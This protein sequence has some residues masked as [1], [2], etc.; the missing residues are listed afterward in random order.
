LG[1]QK[2]IGVDQVRATRIVKDA[3]Q[4]NQLP[5]DPFPTA[6]L[7]GRAR[8][9]SLDELKTVYDLQHLVKCIEHIYRENEYESWFAS[10]AYGYNLEHH[11]DP[12]WQ[13]WRERF[14]SSVYRVFLAGALLYRAYQAP[15]VLA[16]DDKPSDFLEAAAATLNDYRTNDEELWQEQVLTARDIRYLL[17][18][19]VF[20][21]EAYETH[22]PVFGQLAELLFNLSK[23]RALRNDYIPAPVLTMSEGQGLRRRRRVETSEPAE[24]DLVKR[25][26]FY[27]TLEFLLAVEV[28]CPTA[29]SQKVF[30]D[31]L[32]TLHDGTGGC[33]SGTHKLLEPA[34]PTRRVSVVRFG[35]FSLEEIYS[36]CIVEDAI[37]K[38][39]VSMPIDNQRGFRDTDLLLGLVFRTSGQA[40]HYTTRD[41]A[42]HPPLQCVQYIFRKYFNLRFADSAFG[43]DIDD[44]Y[45]EFF[46][47]G[48]LFCEDMLRSYSDDGRS[49][50][51]GLLISADKPH[52]HLNYQ[53]LD[54]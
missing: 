2:L 33:Q 34:Q 36:P 22:D 30:L 16:T 51:R 8:P 7:S 49:I 43:M 32:D 31:G 38:V 27:E 4:A 24:S 25:V 37:A 20:N 40:N 46:S 12:P 1:Y 14:Y 45:R 35:Q 10:N 50:A 11:P 13:H 52:G 21:F 29:R 5:P 47:C 28:L 53:C 44:P 54:F 17:K 26:L 23:D 41:Q 9:P 6:G 19:P 3:V 18:F 48:E 42:A 39:P 15:H